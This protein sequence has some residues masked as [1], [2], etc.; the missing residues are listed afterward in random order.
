[1]DKRWAFGL[2][3]PT[4]L[5]STGALAG[6]Q[7]K[8]FI[9]Y[10]AKGGDLKVNG[11]Y[12]IEARCSK[13]ADFPP[14]QKGGIFPSQSFTA[15]HAVLATTSGLTATAD[16]SKPPQNLVSLALPFAVNNA[17]TAGSQVDN[18]QDCDTN[19]LIKGPSPLF[20]TP[21]FSVSTTTNPGAIAAAFQDVV[22][23]AT[24][25]A[26]VVTGTP[27]KPNITKALGDVQGALPPLQNL[28]ALLFPSTAST[29]QST[30]PLQVGT[31]IVDT[32][33]SRLRLTVCPVASIIADKNQEYF[34][35]FNKTIDRLAYNDNS[36]TF[37][38]ATLG[39]AGFTSPDDQAYGLA[40][41][42]IKNVSTAPLLAQCLGA[43]CPSAIAAKMDPILWNAAPS[44]KPTAE[45]CWDVV[46]P[47]LVAESQPPWSQVGPV[48]Q[49]MVNLY[50]QYFVNA[51]APPN[52]APFSDQNLVSKI[53]IDDQTATLL[54]GGAQFE[55]PR[56]V[57]D[58]LK[59]KGFSRLG[60]Y[61]G[62]TDTSMTYNARA[63]IVGMK[64]DAAKPDQFK[65]SDAIA[66]Y[67]L[68]GGGKIV[69]LVV[70]SNPTD[71]SNS[72]GSSKA[73]GGLAVEA[74][75]AAQITPQ[76]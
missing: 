54:F 17:S 37:V 35:D 66:L 12:A 63:S 28:F 19:Y 64:I 2:I 72:I 16:L 42:A 65:T 43:L 6:A 13:S 33:Y 60:C 41:L 68:W 29:E 36:C 8:H 23:I 70:S 76:K 1:M 45:Q 57:F 48:I 9:V 50:G 31:T 26:P 71:I 53:V 46:P 10:S 39:L 59:T 40:R 20:L 14:P 75:A 5:A 56:G 51:S 3:L 49:A 38:P 15:S 24:S 44:R 7:Q 47:P 73:C 34:N 27:L 67:P 69:K 18:R 25:L 74:A 52:L 55:E 21:T 11:L 61:Q 30:Y 58:V 62:V 22:T 32:Y 4:V